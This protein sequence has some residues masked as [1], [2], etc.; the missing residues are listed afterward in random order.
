[1]AVVV[2]E[3]VMLGKHATVASRGKM[4]GLIQERIGSSPTP[5]IAS[6]LLLSHALMSDKDNRW[7]MASCDR[8]G[9]ADDVPSHKPMA[10][11]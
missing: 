7:N 1:M 8:N 2:H 6:G 11:W 4:Q 3:T 10:A 9:Q 5:W